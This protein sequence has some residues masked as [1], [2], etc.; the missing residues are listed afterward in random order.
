MNHFNSRRSIGGFSL[1]ELLIVVAV[2]A[3]LGSIAFPAY[4]ESIQK[5]RRSDAKI[6][7]VQAAA[8]EERWF[9]GNNAYTSSATNIGGLFS[10]EGYYDVSVIAGTLT[11]TITVTA[12][13]S[14]LDDTDC[15]TFSITQTGLKSSTDSGGSASSECW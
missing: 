5:S 2:I 11:Y 9:T 4:Q 6:A 1:I 10:P 14:Q 8:S 12:N 15:K 13:G 3:L 7:L